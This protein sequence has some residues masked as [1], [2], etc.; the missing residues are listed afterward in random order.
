MTHCGF[1]VHG[2]TDTFYDLEGIS[3][4][5]DRASQLVSYGYEQA[6]LTSV[7]G[8]NALRV[9]YANSVLCASISPGPLNLAL[10]PTGLHDGPWHSL[11]RSKKVECIQA[12][13]KV[14]WRIAD[15][16]VAMDSS[17]NGLYIAD[18]DAYLQGIGRFNAVQPDPHADR[19]RN[20]VQA[21]LEAQLAA[22]HEST[23]WRLTKPIRM[24]ANGI[25]RLRP[26][27][28]TTSK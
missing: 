26:Q 8:G 16:L 3:H 18:L 17:G 28:N 10:I 9:F 14:V 1:S 21:M 13:A 6:R 22:M 11:E 7:V 25:K 15:A 5:A 4:G 19:R 27:L 23:S 20:G 12:I 24:V 2:I